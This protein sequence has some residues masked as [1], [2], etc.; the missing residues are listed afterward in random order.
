LVPLTAAVLIAWHLYT[1][2]RADTSLSTRFVLSGIGASA[3]IVLT[4]TLFGAFG[5]LRPAPVAI[6]NGAL[7][8]LLAAAAVRR[9]GSLRTILTLLGRDLRAFAGTARAALAWETLLLAGILLFAGLWI[10]TAVAFYPPRGI[11]DVTYHL[12]PIYQA[13]QDGRLVLLPVELRGHFAYPLNGELLFLWVA[14]FT[15]AIHWID[16]PQ[17]LLWL[18]GAAA[19]FAIGRRFTLSPRGAFL[20]AALVAVMPVS[21]LQAPS[22]Y[23]DLIS[24]GW[25]LAATVALWHFEDTGSRF[26]LLLAGLAVGLLAGTKASTLPLAAL[27]VAFGVFLILRGPRKNRAA[28]IGVFALTVLAPCVYWYGRDWLLLGNPIFPYPVRVLGATIFHGTLEIGRSCWSV[29]FADPAEVVRIALWDPG[30]GTFHGGFGFLF[31]GFAVPAVALEAVRTL[32]REGP[33]QPS[34][35]L[36]LSLLPWGMATLFLVGYADLFVF[37]RLV[38]CV[39]APASVAFARL[40]DDLRDRLPG[41]ATSLRGLA[42]A[43]AAVSVVLMGSARWPLM[44]LTAVAA[45]EPYLRSASELKYLAATAWDLRVMAGAWAPLDAM[46]REGAGL[47]VYQAADWSVFWTAPTFG[48]ELQNRVWNF[49]PDP[50]HP[51]QAF[52]FHSWTG[53]PTYLGRE[54]HRETVA[55][56]QQLRLVAAER[57]DATTLYV[58]GAALA[59]K[60][61]SQRLAAYYRLTASR[62]VAATAATASSLEAGSVLLAT[63]PMA[64]GYLVHEAD[65][66]LHTTLCPVAAKDQDVLAAAWPGKIIYT[67]GHPIAGRPSTIAASLSWDGPTIS[68][69]RNDPIQTPGASGQ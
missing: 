39:G 56:D 49:S 34:R 38:L 5:H 40:V 45:D 24:T 29:I 64:A 21:L 67:L 1:A 2:V 35:I 23:V 57:S 13:I 9:A 7:S 14:L 10:A 3:Q 27:L 19:V 61:R 11:D 44:N 17:G 54:I 15:H 33:T 53:Q 48:V 55:E 51:P 63:F 30:L 68:V 52:M 26:G 36:I 58:S 65:G 59:E 4:L 25:L 18:Y 43:S 37:A 16:V 22:N 12:P 60:G 20:A 32:R 8:L 62:A 28:A 50:M 69:Y 31:W 46:T 42:V 6:T 66:R 41:A 47:T